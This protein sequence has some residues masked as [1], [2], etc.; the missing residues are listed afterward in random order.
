VA[1]NCYTVLGIESTAPPEDV[2][3]AFR[4]QIAKY[5]PDKVQHLGEEFQAIAAE[6]TTELNEAYR[7]LGNPERRADYDRH[8]PLPAPGAGNVSAPATAAVESQPR[9]DRVEST[10]TQRRE[11]TQQAGGERLTEERGSF[12][13]VVR[14]ATLGRF[15][16]ALAVAIGTGYAESQM[17]GFDVVSAP[18]P[19]LFGRTR[20]PVLVARFV[21]RV[22]ADTIAQAWADASSGGRAAHQQVLV[23]LIG[24]SVAAEGEVARAIADQRRRSGGARDVTV[25]T[26]NANDWTARRPADSPPLVDKVLACLRTAH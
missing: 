5:H 22:D 25:V 21:S 3:H 15:R 26:V 8:H 14:R 17:T 6:R 11:K 4:V 7:I 19:M 13:D 12:D 10:F 23:F 18:K 20:G 1:R 16:Q 2:K 9:S 24:V